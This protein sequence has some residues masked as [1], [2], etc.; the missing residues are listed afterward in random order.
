MNHNA[1]EVLLRVEHIDK[2]FG[3]THA[4]KDISFDILPGEICGL[5]GENGSGKSTVSSI[6]SGLLKADKGQMQFLGKPYAPQTV[7]EANKLGVCMIVQEQS[8]VDTVTVAANIFLG[9]EA[10][11]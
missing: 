2:S 7:I 8:T 3:S 10:P 5:I 9:A 6:I 4:L 11:L 1:G